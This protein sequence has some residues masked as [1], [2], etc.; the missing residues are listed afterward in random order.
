MRRISVI[1][2]AVLLL[3]VAGWFAMHA[4]MAAPD[5]LDLSRSK[6]SARGIYL[7][8]IEPE[9]IPVQQNVLHSWFLTLSTPDG[10]AVEDARIT[11]DGGMPRH[12]HG[13]PTKPQVTQ[14]VG[15]GRYKIE[16]VRFSMTGWWELK[17][18]ISAAPGDDDVVFNL[19]L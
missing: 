9:L 19:M 12:G 16:G 3:A 4:F 1:A 13:L 14:Y 8:S 17:F 11:V 10:T 15:D 18:A 5:D 6:S 7:V 2:V